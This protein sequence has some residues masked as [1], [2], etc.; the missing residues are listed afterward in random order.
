MSSKDSR[1]TASQPSK[2]ERLAKALRENLAR[3]KALMR[4]KRE[5]AADPDAPSATLADDPTP[6]DDASS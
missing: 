3:R 1:P 6:E 5:R 4:S 2:E